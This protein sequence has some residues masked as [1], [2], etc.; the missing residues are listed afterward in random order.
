MKIKSL[1]LVVGVSI[2]LCGCGRTDGVK[3]PAQAALPEGTSSGGG[4][5]GDENSMKLL[6]WSKG[7]TAASIRRANP[8]VLAGLPAGWNAER[9]ARLIENTQAE[10]RKEAYRYNRELMFDYRQPAKG[11]PQLVATALFFRAH[12][13]VPVNSD[14]SEKME[15]YL[16][17]IRTKLLHEAAHVMGIGLSE[18]ADIKARAFSAF[19]TGEVLAKNNLYCKV[20]EV[21]S[22]Y[23]GYVDPKDTEVKPESIY[24]WI[25]NRP[26][27]FALQDLRSPQLVDIRYSWIEELKAG[28]PW[29][30]ASFVHMPQLKDN[31]ASSP[32]YLRYYT[33]PFFVRQES[34]RW[35]SQYYK[36]FSPSPSGGVVLAG[37]EEVYSRR[38]GSVARQCRYE[39]KLEIPLRQSGTYQ[40]IISFSDTCHFGQS[41]EEVASSAPVVGSFVVECVESMRSLDN[42]SEFFGDG[43][44]T[45]PWLIEWEKNYNLFD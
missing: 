40:A 17:E 24:T 12:S 1:L 43:A 39:E 41:R 44:F 37:S 25:I 11:E 4:G 29:S 34:I 27:G 2:A 6:N 10:P 28:R 16:R 23:P 36:G 18:T 45:D 42:I 15:P 7:L 31:D 8:Q 13:A 35:S 5:F 26:T 38:T 32:E 19:L 20:N 22:S 9:L 33:H 14:Y 30:F 21:P 3:R